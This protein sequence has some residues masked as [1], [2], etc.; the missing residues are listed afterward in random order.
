MRKYEL[1][2]VLGESHTEDEAKEI[3]K[4]IEKIIE[5]SGGKVEKNFF[6]GKKKLAYK[7]AKNSFG[8]YFI[9]IFVIPPASLSKLTRDLNL[10]EK[11]I[12]FLITGFQEGFSFWEE[13]TGEKEAKR[14]VKP[15]EEARIRPIKPV[16]VEEEE[17]V[18][19]KLDD[20]IKVKREKKKTKEAKEMEKEISDEERQKELDKKLAELLK[21]E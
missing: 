13:G 7:I 14:R 1:A 20:Q 16:A 19:E 21:E 9:L 6:W 10:G 17:K 15:K 11:I 8:Y 2:F 18:E 12:R 5:N 4:D 3:S